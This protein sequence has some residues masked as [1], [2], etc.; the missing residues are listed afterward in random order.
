[1]VDVKEIEDVHVDI[2]E[3]GLRSHADLTGTVELDSE[4]VDAF[5]S[6]LND[7]IQKYQLT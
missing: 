7:L 1:M 3:D 4:E 5:L 2:S 6:D